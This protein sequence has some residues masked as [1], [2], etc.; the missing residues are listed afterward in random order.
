ME[1]FTS[2]LKKPS[3]SQEKSTLQSCICP[4]FTVGMS[5]SRSNIQ[6]LRPNVQLNL[7]RHAVNRDT[8]ASATA[9][10]VMLEGGER[11]GVDI[12]VIDTGHY[13]FRVFMQ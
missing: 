8:I 12:G 5:Y 10:G 13:V 11:Y 9:A 2:L 6:Y 3:Q 4:V 7:A 1:V